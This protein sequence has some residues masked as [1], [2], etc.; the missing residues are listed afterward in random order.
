MR[1]KIIDLTTIYFWDSHYNFYA[2]KSTFVQLLK[3]IVSNGKLL[4]LLEHE[5]IDA[6]IA[7]EIAMYD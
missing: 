1:D 6:F 7:I 3:F 4:M 5:Q 2:H